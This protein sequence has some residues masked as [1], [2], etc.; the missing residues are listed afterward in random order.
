MMYDQLLILNTK[1]R[2]IKI[3]NSLQGLEKVFSWK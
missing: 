3:I 2:N 1:P